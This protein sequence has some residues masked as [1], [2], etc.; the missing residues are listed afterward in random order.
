[1]SVAPYFRVSLKQAK[2]V[3]A[4]MSKAVAQWRKV[5]RALGMSVAELDRFADAFEHSERMR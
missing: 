2:E 1:M 4:R 5:G 3:V